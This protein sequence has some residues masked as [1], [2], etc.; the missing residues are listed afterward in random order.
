MPSET[1]CMPMST[2]ICFLKTCRMMSP[3]EW[4]TLTRDD[5]GSMV[6]KVLRH[7][8]LPHWYYKHVIDKGRNDCTVFAKRLCEMV[9]LCTDKPFNIN[10]IEPFE[11]LFN[12]QILVISAKLANKFIRIGENEPDKK[13][14]ISV[15]GRARWFSTFFSHHKYHRILFF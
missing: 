2:V 8:S 7:R 3:T 10:E 5:T 4:R 15:F 6:D 13:K 1:L 9:G 12:L 11:R 14:N